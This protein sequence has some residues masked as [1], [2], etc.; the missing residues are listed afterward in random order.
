[1]TRGDLIKRIESRRL[2][3]WQTLDR[4]TVLSALDAAVSRQPRVRGSHP[5]RGAR[6]GRRTARRVP[7][8]TR[9]D[10]RCCKG[11]DLLFYDPR[12]VG[13]EG[14][15]GGPHETSRFHR[16]ARRHRTHV[17][18]RFARAVVSDA[19]RRV[20]RTG[21]CRRAIAL[22]QDVGAGGQPSLQSSRRPIRAIVLSISGALMTG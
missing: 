5:G 16:A 2:R 14:S 18:N 17:A 20:A 11:R 13:P 15:V 4:Y 22:R 1:M 19:T 8:D 6:V 9:P 12:A 3:A 10:T 7:A 21:T